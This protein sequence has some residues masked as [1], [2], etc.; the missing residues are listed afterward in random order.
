MGGVDGA[1]KW[2]VI[3]RRRARGVSN[4]K[5]SF[6][7]AYLGRGGVREGEAGCNGVWLSFG[8]GERGRYPGFAWLTWDAAGYK[9]SL[10]VH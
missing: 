6:Y 8:G 9:T 1:A 3:K 7:V 5:Y 2:S 4:V 10:Y